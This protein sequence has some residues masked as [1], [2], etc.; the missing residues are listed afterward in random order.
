MTNNKYLISIIVLIIINFI[1]V[2]L[3]YFSSSN[4]KKE[5]K[6][7]KNE[8]DIILMEEAKLRFI[9]DSL[10]KLEPKIR[11]KTIKIKEE[12][13]TQEHE[14][15]EIPGIVS[16]YSEHKLDSILSNHRFKPRAKSG[17]SINH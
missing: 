15:D 6:T 10:S 13:K 3:W 4:Y 8:R 11:W 2:G 17:N 14:T 1:V 12:L 9:N 7:I 5:I 16:T